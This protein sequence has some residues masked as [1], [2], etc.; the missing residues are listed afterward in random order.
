[1]GTSVVSMEDSYIYPL[2]FQSNFWDLGFFLASGKHTKNDGKSWNITIFNR[3]ITIFNSFW[4]QT[5]Q[6]DPSSNPVI[7][8]V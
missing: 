4:Y 3:K 5:I 6:D 2:G 1:M 7:F 8:T